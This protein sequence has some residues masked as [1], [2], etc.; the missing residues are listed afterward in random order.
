M[1]KVAYQG[2]QGA[3]SEAAI[4]KHFGHDVGA[5]GYNTFEEVFNA[6]ADYAIVPMEN[7]T[8]GSILINYDLLLKY[9]K[10]SK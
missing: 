4:Y 7:T 9:T 1:I 2:I 5:I 10:S 6:G 3:Y 8:T